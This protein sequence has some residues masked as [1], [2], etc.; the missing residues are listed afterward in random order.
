MKN[1]FTFTSTGLGNHWLVECKTE[2]GYNR[3]LG[4]I[5]E[6]KKGKEISWAI[7]KIGHEHDF[8][9]KTPSDLRWLPAFSSKEDAAKGLLVIANGINANPLPSHL[10]DYISGRERDLNRERTALLE[11][12]FNVKYEMRILESLAAKYNLNFDFGVNIKKEVEDLKNFL[13]ENIELIYKKFGKDWAR[14]LRAHIAGVVSL[15]DDN[16]AQDI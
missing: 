15:I 13:D 4:T 2:D 10:R 12:L 9:V 3:Q 14:S 16:I 1:D 6:I 5:V 8:K 11:R 7:S